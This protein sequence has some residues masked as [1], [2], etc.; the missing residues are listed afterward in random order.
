MCSLGHHF[1]VPYKRKLSTN[2]TTKAP[3]TGKHPVVISTKHLL[4]LGASYQTVFISIIG[5]TPSARALRQAKPSQ[6]KPSQA[7]PSQAKPSHYDFQRM[8]LSRLLCLLTSLIYPSYYNSKSFIQYAIL[9]LFLQVT[10]PPQFM[11]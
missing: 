10:F 11:P 5:Q 2:K 1:V 4:I 3:R 9:H 7:K 6:A 8:K